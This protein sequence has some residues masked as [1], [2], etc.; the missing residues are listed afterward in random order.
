MGKTFDKTLKLQ[1]FTTRKKKVKWRK[2]EFKEFSTS[3][4]YEMGL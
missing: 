1:R 4:N 2:E 3:W